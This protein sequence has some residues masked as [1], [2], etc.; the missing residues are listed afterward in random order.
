MR[1]CFYIIRASWRIGRGR[2]YVWRDTPTDIVR[3]VAVLWYLNRKRGE[4]KSE[5]IYEAYKEYKM[6]KARGQA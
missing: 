6:R 1:F 2:W 5:L 3:Q 4:E